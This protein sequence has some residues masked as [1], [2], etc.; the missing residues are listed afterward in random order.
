VPRPPCLLAAGVVNGSPRGAIFLFGA[1]LP[2]PITDHLGGGRVGKALSPVSPCAGFFLPEL[3]PFAPPA[4]RPLLV[5][6]PTVCFL[7]PCQI[8]F[9]PAAFFFNF[10]GA[11]FRFFV[12]TG[13]KKR[14]GAF[15]PCGRLL[16]FWRPSYIPRPTTPN[17][18]RRAK[19]VDYPSPGNWEQFPLWSP[20]F[21][22]RRKGKC[23]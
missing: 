1:I 7:L 15:L 14:A 19:T 9:Q 21:P 4:P 5:V 23:F 6:P 17:L 10:A 22:A 12:V 18:T 11:L 3:P 20:L 16:F 13:P 2:L 8:S